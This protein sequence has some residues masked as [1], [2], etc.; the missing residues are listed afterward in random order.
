MRDE[1]T[2]NGHGLLGFLFSAAVATVND[3]VA[4]LR[5]LLE[6]CPESLVLDPVTRTG[7]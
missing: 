6:V 2:R 4:E 5:V 1:L 3:P 7:A